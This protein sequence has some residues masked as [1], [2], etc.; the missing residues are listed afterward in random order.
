MKPDALPDNLADW[1]AL[2]ERRHGVAIDLGLERCSTVWRQM[3]CPRPAPRVFMVA[4]TNGKGST[5]ATLCAL[6]GALGYRYGSYTSPHITVYN[7]RVRV[8]GKPV[9]DRALIESFLN[10]EAARGDR[11]LSYFEFGTLA[12]IDLLA[13]AELDFAVL[14]VGLGGRLD[15]VNLI[16]TDCAVITPIGLDHQAYLGDDLLSI[17]REKA[18]IIRPLKPVISGESDPPETIVETAGQQKAPLQRLGREFSIE[19]RNGHARFTRGG[20]SLELPLPALDGPHQLNNM[21]TA[22]AALLTL[23]PTA[24][25]RPGALATGLRSVSIRGRFQRI[26]QS[27][28]VWVDVGH[29]PMAAR[30]VAAALIDARKAEKLK[31]IRCVLAILADKDAAGV[32][33]ELMPLVSGWYCAGLEDDRGQSGAQLAAR[34]KEAHLPIQ[35]KEYE[36]VSEAIDAALAESGPHDGVLVFG[37]FYTAAET[38]AH[39]RARNHDS[40]PGMLIESSSSDRVNG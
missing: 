34:L 2:L 5:V 3:G 31:N 29:N 23:I 14:E 6:L 1:L 26:L 16:D 7:E 22:V 33:R 8:N 30:A 27:P 9:S 4:G 18:G 32:V 37:S 38:L 15:A 25:D 39:T 28:A 12:A 11:D 13:R 24:A 36:R 20:L 35:V 19:R 40:S 21:A 17:G 10:I